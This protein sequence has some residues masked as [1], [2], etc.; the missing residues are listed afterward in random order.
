MRTEIVNTY[1]YD[2]MVELTY[3]SPDEALDV[4]KQAYRGYINKYQF[5]KEG[6]EYT[7]SE[8]DAY[9]I[10]WAFNVAYRAL[11]LKDDSEDERGVLGE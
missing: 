5:P 4:L 6:Q 11:R 8:Y 10:Q 2:D 1:D 9:K 3:M 7:E